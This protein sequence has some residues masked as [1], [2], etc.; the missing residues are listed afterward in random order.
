MKPRSHRESA[1]SDEDDGYVVTFVA[2]LNAHNTG[3]V[4][5]LDAK[6]F[7]AGPIRASRFHSACRP[8][9]TRPG[10]PAINCARSKESL[11]GFPNRRLP[12][13][14]GRCPGFAV[15]TSIEC[16]APVVLSGTIVCNL[17]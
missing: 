16:G 13:M 8:G 1:P 2:D 11:R 4:I 7:A 9:S 17:P 3:E 5:I 12:S 6:N 15:S 10:I 14:P